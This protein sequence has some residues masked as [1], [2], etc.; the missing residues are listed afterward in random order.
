MLIVQNLFHKE[1]QDNFIKFELVYYNTKK[2]RERESQRELERKEKIRSFKSSQYIQNQERER[3]SGKRNII[4][5]NS[6]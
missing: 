5:I 2:E 4:N 3:E 1:V 6:N